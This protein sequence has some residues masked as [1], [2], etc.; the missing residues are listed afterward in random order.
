MR[1]VL[2]LGWYDLKFL[3]IIKSQA[4]ENEK[5][6]EVIQKQRDEINK[7]KGENG[8]SDIKQS[9]KA[10]NDFSCDKERK[11]AE[12]CNGNS[13]K[14]GFKLDIGSLQELKE[15]RIPVDVPES[16]GKKVWQ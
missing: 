8:K 11:E 6:K 1:G 7:L 16:L 14:E 10:E 13:K 15:Q 4:S 5:L 2:L 3:N 9:E 12:R